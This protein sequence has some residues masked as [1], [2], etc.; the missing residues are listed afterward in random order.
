MKKPIMIAL[1]SALFLAV[2]VTSALVSIKVS[3]S[4]PQKLFR[5]DYRGAVY[6]DLAYGNANGHRYDLY[7]PDSADPSQPQN[8]ILFIHG[9]SFNSGVKEE[10]DAWCKFYASHGYITATLDYILQNQGIPADLNLMNEEILN[11]VAAIKGLAQTLGITFNGM[12]VCG[13]SAGG[14]LAMNYAY[15][16]ANT[17]AVP[18]KFVFQLAGPADF[19]P[20]DW[21][22]LIR[23]NKWE[24]EKKFVEQM[25]GQALTDEQMENGEYVE[26]IDHISPARLVSKDSVPTLCGYGLKDHLVPSSS[27]ESLVKALADCGVPYD[28]L[29]F[30]NS[31]HGMYADL[32]VLQDFIDLSLEYCA[33][34]FSFHSSMIKVRQS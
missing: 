22:I 5:V 13:V 20:S 17:S 18:V 21:E 19:E 26:Y 9:G 30:P 25:T 14:T 34:F 33:L 8:L 29:P 24:T 31:N 12:A 3:G 28:Y 6:T 32:D 4:A 11:C 7:I 15:K 1:Y 2:F 27:R 23:V 10:G 16:C